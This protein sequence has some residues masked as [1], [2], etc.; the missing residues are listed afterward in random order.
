MSREYWANLILCIILGACVIYVVSGIGSV[1]TPK[2]LLVSDPEPS[3]EVS[4]FISDV[5]LTQFGITHGQ[6]RQVSA[7]FYIHNNTEQ[8]VKNVQILCEFFDADGSYLDREKWIL[9]GTFPGGTEVKST[10]VS[11]R[12]IHVK[13]PVDCRVAD[14]QL[15]GGPIFKLHRSSGGGHGETPDS[16]DGGHDAPHGSGH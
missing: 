9:Y 6:D 10:S 14:L 12:Y 3:E 13:G 1:L 16:G 11:D 4:S 5:K 2:G 7:E 15:A 8:D